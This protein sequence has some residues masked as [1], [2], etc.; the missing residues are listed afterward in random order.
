MSTEMVV[1]LYITV[2]YINLNM[3]CVFAMHMLLAIY[4]T[5]QLL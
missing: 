4:N 1:L 2:Y 5:Q 3:L